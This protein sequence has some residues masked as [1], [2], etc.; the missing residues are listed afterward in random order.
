M[1]IRVLKPGLLATVQDC[2]RPRWQAAGVPEGGAADR[3]S[4]RLANRLLG[5][6]ADAATLEVA[7]RRQ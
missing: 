7:P 5:N 2:G 4:H 3:W 1:T 6:P